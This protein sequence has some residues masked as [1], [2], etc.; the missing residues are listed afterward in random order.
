[1]DVKEGRVFQV[2][3]ERRGKKGVPSDRSTSCKGRGPHSRGW[4]EGRGPL[5]AVSVNRAWAVVL[6]PE[7]LGA[8]VARF[9]Q[10]GATVRLAGGKPHPWLPV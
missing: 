8:I 1:M 9:Q 6:S 2:A 4:E 7:S 5:T 10:E 3:G